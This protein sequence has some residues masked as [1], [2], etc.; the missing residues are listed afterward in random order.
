MENTLYQLAAPADGV[1]GIRAADPGEAKVEK[2][3]PDI[4]PIRRA[5]HEAARSAKTGGWNADARADR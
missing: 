2:V 4:I 5:V 3:A 1:L